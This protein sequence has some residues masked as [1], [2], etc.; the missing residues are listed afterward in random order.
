MRAL[1]SSFIPNVVTTIPGYLQRSWNDV[2][3]QRDYQEAGAANGT[4]FLL[5]PLP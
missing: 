2:R 1:C 5:G 3:T 4:R